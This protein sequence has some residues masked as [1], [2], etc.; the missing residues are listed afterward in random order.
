[1]SICPSSSICLPICLYLHVC[2]PVCLYH[3]TQFVSIY[4]TQFFS[5]MSANLALFISVNLSLSMSANLSLSVCQFVSIYVSQFVSIYEY[6]QLVIQSNLFNHRC[7]ISTQHYMTRYIAVHFFR[8]YI[9]LCVRGVVIYIILFQTSSTVVIYMCVYQCFYSLT[10]MTT[11]D[12]VC[13]ASQ[14][15]CSLIN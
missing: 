9:D 5:V 13:Q 6:S 1:M 7:S 11:L 15:S 10:K 3:V 8:A 14:T 12:I 4:V 2:H